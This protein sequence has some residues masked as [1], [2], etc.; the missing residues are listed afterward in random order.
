MT[1]LWSLS[2]YASQYSTQTHR[3]YPNREAQLAGAEKYIDCISA[4][5]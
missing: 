3:C 2:K 5:R 4:E 1:C